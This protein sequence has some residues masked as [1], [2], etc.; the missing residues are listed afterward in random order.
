[1]GPLGAPLLLHE[2]LGDRNYVTRM[3]FVIKEY[4]I[5]SR[6]ANIHTQPKREPQYSPVVRAVSSN[7]RFQGLILGTTRAPEWIHTA[8]ED[9]S[10]VHIRN[11]QEGLHAEH[12][13]WL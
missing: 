1:M 10:G 2:L 12:G 7:P 5:H 3:L 9:R 13:A 11:H 8:A 6:I 4:I